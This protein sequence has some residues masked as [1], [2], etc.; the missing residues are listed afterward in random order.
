MVDLQDRVLLYHAE[1]QQQAE[2]GKYIHGL[3]GRQQ[4]L[5]GAIAWSYELLEEP[6]ARV[7]L[8]SLGI[9]LPL[10]EIYRDIELAP[11]EPDE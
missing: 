4:T 8:E 6:G 1:K 2:A 3:P 11:V 7:R 10:D 5:R 9:D